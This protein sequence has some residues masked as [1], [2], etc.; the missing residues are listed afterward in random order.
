MLIE[1]DETKYKVIVS[2]NSESAPD[3]A[4][5]DLTDDKEFLVGKAP[6]AD[7]KCQDDVLD[8][9]HCYVRA[10]GDEIWFTDNYTRYGC[11]F[12]AKPQEW[13]ALKSNGFCL[14]NTIF[15]IRPKDKDTF[16]FD[17]EGQRSKETHI[18]D[19]VATPTLFIGR[20]S[21]DKIMLA[22]DE[23]VSAHHA[24]LKFDLA[25]RLWTI[26]DHGR[27]GT[28]SS[29]GTWVKI[30]P[31]TIFVHLDEVIRIGKETFLTFKRK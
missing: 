27:K 17:R 12:R 19:A 14:G 15:H 5:Y 16:F 6:D 29:N 3:D 25:S 11:F 21:N 10:V 18:I 4:E 7:I 23:T 8:E 1:E 13:V 26:K 2:S 9:G 22:D 20:E 30:G 28:G 31:E 24:Q